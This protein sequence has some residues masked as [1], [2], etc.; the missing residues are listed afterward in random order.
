MERGSNRQTHLFRS[1]G[2][3]ARHVGRVSWVIGG[4][5]RRTEVAPPT[6]SRRWSQRALNRVVILLRKGNA[7]GGKDPDFWY[8]FEGAEDRWLVMSLTTPDKIRPLQ[9]KLYL[10]AK[11][12]PNFRFYLLYD[13]V[14]RADILRHAYDLAR[15]KRGALGVDG[16]DFAAIEAAGVENWLHGI[17]T[18]LRTKTYQPQPVR[19]VAVPRS[20][21]IAGLAVA[22]HGRRLYLGAT[23]A[24][25]IN[26]RF[27]Q[28]IHG[29]VAR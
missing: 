16:V 19:R 10:K 4:G 3:M 23:H 13:K 27:Q 29:G 15:A 20:G 18:N 5:P 21:A 14:Y 26:N 11:A 7:S 2:V 9:R 1:I 25:L 22:A 12:E 17:E 24:H 6:S 28:T 8:A